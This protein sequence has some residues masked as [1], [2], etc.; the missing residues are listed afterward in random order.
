MTS[1]TLPWV[2]VSLLLLNFNWPRASAWSLSVWR[3]AAPAGSS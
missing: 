2:V 1:V 3:A